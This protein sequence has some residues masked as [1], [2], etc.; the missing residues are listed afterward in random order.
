M[1]IILSTTAIVILSPLLMPIMVILKFTGEGYIF[2]RHERVGQKGKPFN[3]IKFATMYKD[4][5]N[6]VGGNI[7]VKDLRYI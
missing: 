2:Y 6:M 7:T 1:D 3:L 5:P 4:S